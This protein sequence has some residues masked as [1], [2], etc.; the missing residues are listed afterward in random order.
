MATNPAVAR[1]RRDALLRGAIGSGSAYAAC[2]GAAYTGC[3]ACGSAYAACCGAA[4]TGCWGCGS[5]YAAC[6]GAAYTGCWG[7]GSAYAACCGAWFT[8]CCG[9]THAA[10]CGSVA[11][12]SDCSCS[13]SKGCCRP[14][15][16]GSATSLVV[17]RHP[18][19]SL[20]L[21]GKYPSASVG[22][23]IG[24]VR[25]ASA[26]PSRKENPCVKGINRPRGLRI[27]RHSS[28]GG[29]LLQPWVTCRVGIRPQV[30]HHHPVP[31][32]RVRDSMITALPRT[33]TSPR[34]RESQTPSVPHRP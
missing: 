22:K 6:C 17:M 24:S 7:C 31:R 27:R 1:P 25:W 2:C 5:A 10:C 19:D 26:F 21:H 28:F 15:F 13:A 34:P 16:T 4:Y 23:P 33:R 11:A 20:L 12:V 29:I 9:C 30:R 18:F 14:V 8:G 32:W 3:W